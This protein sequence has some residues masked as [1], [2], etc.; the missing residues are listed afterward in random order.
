MN[1]SKQGNPAYDRLAMASIVDAA[2]DAVGGN[3]EEDGDKKDGIIEDDKAGK[4][5]GKELLNVSSEASYLDENGGIVTMK[6]DASR[7]HHTIM[8]EGHTTKALLCPRSQHL[9][10]SHTSSSFPL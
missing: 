9:R 5:E 6:M 8:G 4:T 10:R 3:K 2:V 7:A 1:E